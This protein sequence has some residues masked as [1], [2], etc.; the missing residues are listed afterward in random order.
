MKECRYL[1]PGLALSF[2]TGYALSLLVPI[3]AFRRMFAGVTWK[4]EERYYDELPVQQ[5]DPYIEG[6]VRELHTDQFVVS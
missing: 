5:S 4:K 3:G 2:V 6:L 1:I